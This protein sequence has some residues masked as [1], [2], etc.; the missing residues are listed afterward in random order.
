MKNIEYYKSFD[1][2]DD[3][4]DFLAAA[5]DGMEVKGLDVDTE[6]EPAAR[7]LP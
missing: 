4:I 5:G 7:G 6:Y 2:L 1:N 3:L